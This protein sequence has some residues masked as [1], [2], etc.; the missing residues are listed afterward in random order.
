MSSGLRIHLVM[1]LKLLDDDA[2][3]LTGGFSKVYSTGGNS[4]GLQRLGGNHHLRVLGA[5]HQENEDWSLNW[6]LHPCGSSFI[7]CACSYFDGEMTD[8][9][10]HVIILHED[11]LQN[12]IVAYEFRDCPSNRGLDLY[13]RILEDLH[14]GG[15]NN[16]LEALFDTLE[17]LVTRNWLPSP[18]LP[19]RRR[20]AMTAVVTV[21][22]AA[23]TSTFLYYIYIYMCVFGR[24]R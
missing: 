19:S 18:P 7:C 16:G 4:K 15:T 12:R 6:D 22:T 23:T 11:V 10:L 20:V 9:K 21:M 2:V 17:S 24:E 8:K 13:E 14:E 1:K 3:D 5:V